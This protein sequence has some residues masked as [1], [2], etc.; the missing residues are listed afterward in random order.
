MFVEL[1]AYGYRNLLPLATWTELPLDRGE[2]S[3]L[4]AKV[5]L[6]VL[7][8]V[9]VPLFIP[10]RYIPLN[11]LVRFFP[12][13]FIPFLPVYILH[14]FHQCTDGLLPFII[15]VMLISMLIH[16]RVA[17]Q[18]PQSQPNSEQTASVI[19]LVFFYF[20][21]PLIWKGYSVPHLPYEDLPV[22][23]DYDHADVLR[24]RA[25]K[26]RTPC[27][28]LCNYLSILFRPAPRQILGRAKAPPLLG[29]P[30]RLR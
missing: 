20:L 15:I 14:L 3:M 16:R 18:N 25:F 19:S 5:A 29:Y 30:P 6:L 23:A 9:V 26:V 13:L 24:L 11:P 1:C 8:A 10:R 2:G 12:Y 21:D 17:F 28:L 7:N 4:W 22:L 27:S